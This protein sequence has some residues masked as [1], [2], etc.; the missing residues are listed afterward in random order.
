MTR[1]ET[2]QSA[3]KTA[4]GLVAYQKLMLSNYTTKR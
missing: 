3:S 2:G 1:F 4:G